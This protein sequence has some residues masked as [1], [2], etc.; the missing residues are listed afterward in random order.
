MKLVLLG[1]AGGPRP[2]VHRAAPAQAIVHRDQVHVVDCGNGVARQ[3]AAAGLRL[4]KLAGIYITH[5]HADHMVDVGAL[6]LL[7]WTDGMTEPVGIHGPA[8]I[9]ASVGHFVEMMR[10]ELESRTSTT[11]RAAFPS[12]LHCHDLTGPGVVHE[13]DGL[14]VTATLVDHPPFE[15]AL[16]YRFDGD[17]RSVVISGDTRYSP[18]L[19]ELAT[20]ADVLVHEAIY[21]EALAE[22]LRGARAATLREHLVSC[23]T[24]AQDAGR[25]AKEAGVRTLVLSHLVPHH[26]TVT[27]EMW[28]AA[29]ASQFDGEIIIGRDLLDI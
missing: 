8:G 10:I 20:G 25:L 3:M 26:P 23:H 18:K 2:S 12:L 14:R 11:G 15:H 27:E 13:S 7:A 19:A 9:T 24:T 16:A 4:D 1:T 17:G 5:H 6:P 28:R 29:A 22:Q 21:E